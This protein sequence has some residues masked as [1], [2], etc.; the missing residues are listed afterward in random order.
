ML[1]I[2]KPFQISCQTTF[3]DKTKAANYFL[4][5]A[6]RSQMLGDPFLMSGDKFFDE[7][8]H[9]YVWTFYVVRANL[10]EHLVSEFYYASPM[11]DIRYR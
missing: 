6:V 2:V 9:T 8:T 10:L 3:D 4:G 5:F 11:P 7:K 1:N